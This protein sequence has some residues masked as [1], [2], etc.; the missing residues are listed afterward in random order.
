MESGASKYALSFYLGSFLT[1]MCELSEGFEGPGDWGRLL[2][3]I[4]GIF[5][6]F[7]QI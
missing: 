6:I 4:E 7:K 5:I 1:C 3:R 2:G